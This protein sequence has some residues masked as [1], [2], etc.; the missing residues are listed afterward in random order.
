MEPINK[1]NGEKII[2]EHFSDYF[3]EEINAI[4]YKVIKNV[5]VHGMYRKEILDTEGTLM[6]YDM[7]K[8]QFEESG[9]KYKT[10]ETLDV[11]GIVD[12]VC[13]YLTVARNGT[14]DH[15]RGIDIL[16]KYLVDWWADYVK[17][18]RNIG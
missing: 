17:S 6:S 9:R 18:M 15:L 3:T 14:K 12:F 2:V 16:R 10:Y 5:E 11:D 7:T 8:E 4:I 13:F 1:L